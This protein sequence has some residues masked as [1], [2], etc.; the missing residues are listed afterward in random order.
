MSEQQNFLIESPWV[1]IALPCINQRGA[2]HS[3]SKN[4]SQGT[5]FANYTPYVVK[6]NWDVNNAL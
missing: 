4:I 6:L 5:I 1:L 2:D 3:G